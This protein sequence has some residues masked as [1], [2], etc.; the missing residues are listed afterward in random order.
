MRDSNPGYPRMLYLSRVIGVIA[1]PG[2]LRPGWADGRRQ[3]KVHS[4]PL[5]PVS[6]LVHYVSGA[7]GG[8][9]WPQEGG[10]PRGVGS[11]VT[12]ALTI[13]PMGPVVGQR[14]MSHDVL[15]L[16]VLRVFLREVL[17]SGGVGTGH[18]G[19]C[20]SGL[21]W[22]I[23]GM[24]RRSKERIDHLVVRY[25]TLC[26]SLQKITMVNTYYLLAAQ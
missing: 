9:R 22:R 13:G 21:I 24:E 26:M 23:K 1:A 19:R 5:S 16:R 6:G 15:Q 7:P 12:L 17:R 11:A 2:A 4:A 14:V 18:T 10:R 3:A 8:R 20:E 25:K